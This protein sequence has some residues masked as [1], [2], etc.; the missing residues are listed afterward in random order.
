MILAHLDTVHPVGTLADE[1]PW[2]EAGE[3]IYGPGVYDMKAGALMALYGLKLAA[4]Q[5]SPDFLQ[6]TILFAPDEETGSVTSQDIIAREA[7]HAK[8]VLV[9][10]PARD[11]GKIVTARKGVGLFDIHIIGRPSHAGSKP[12][13]G[14]SAIK[15]A[16][17]IVLA[18]DALNDPVRGVTVTT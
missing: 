10:E 8:F 14:R 17:R 5:P 12:L 4:E 9:V 2:R 7:E 16:A 6:T 11:G 18:L 3:R 15:E 1:L 13:E